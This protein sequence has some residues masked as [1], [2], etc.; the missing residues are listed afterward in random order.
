MKRLERE[1]FIL[2]AAKC[3]TTTLAHWLGSHPSVVMSQPKEPIFFEYEYQMGLAHY[4]SKYFSD[5]WRGE[6]WPLEARHRNLF[7]PFIPERIEASVDDPYFLV[8]LREPVHRAYADWWHWRSR[9]KEPLSF[10]AA[11]ELDRDRLERGIELSE[12]LWGRTLDPVDGRN[13]LRT[14]LDSGFYAE[15]TKR[16]IDRFGG[17]RVCVVF[18]EEWA[19]SC[20]PLECAVGSLPLS[21]EGGLDNLDLHVNRGDVRYAYPESLQV[22]KSLRQ[23]LPSRLMPQRIKEGLKPLLLQRVSR[24][25]IEAGARKQLADLYRERNRELESLLGRDVPSGW[26]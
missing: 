23:R 2:G 1:I 24:P 4:W 22:L 12:D 7:L 21:P 25:E 13:E 16:Y 26:D 5:S 9:G 10:E 14:Y 19:E 15:Q 20:L 18:L 11:I 17:D 6:A 3:G 8:T